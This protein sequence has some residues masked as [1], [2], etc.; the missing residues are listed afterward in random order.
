MNMKLKTINKVLTIFDILDKIDSIPEFDFANDHQLDFV[1][2]TTIEYA[3]KSQVANAN[4]DADDDPTEI[5]IDD[6]DD[7][8]DGYVNDTS[9]MDNQL[10]AHAKDR[11]NETNRPMRVLRDAQNPLEMMS[12]TEFSRAF[13]FS[14]DTVQD[15]LKMLSYGLAKHTN[16]G[17][18]VSPMYELLITLRFL[19]SGSYQTKMCKNVSQPTISRILK[20]V[21]TLLSEQRLRFIKIPERNDYK[22]IATEFMQHGGFPEVFGCIGSTHIAIKSPG[23]NLSDGYLNEMGFYSFRAM[24]SLYYLYYDYK[25]IKFYIFTTDCV[26]SRL[27]IL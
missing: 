9:E 19:A 25:Y 6:N 1:H 3:K 27:A 20:R 12:E 26:R 7:D 22:R 8:N 16:R 4:D 21:T 23:R 13:R 2:K 18:P 11:K 15:I 24:V 14:K 10:D 17:Q 5:D